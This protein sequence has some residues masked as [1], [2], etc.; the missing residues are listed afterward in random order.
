MFVYGTG[1]GCVDTIQWEGFREGLDDIRY[2]TKLLQ[3]AQPLSHCRDTARRYPAKKALQLLADA[4]GDDMDLT[5]LRLEMIRHIQR[6][7]ALK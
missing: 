2:A 7:M 6:L 1:D 5:T 4:D 3:L